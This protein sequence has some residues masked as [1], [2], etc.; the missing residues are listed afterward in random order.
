MEAMKA[1][2]A[3]KAMKIAVTTIT[4]KTMK[5]VKTMK[6]M[7]TIM[8]FN[9]SSKRTLWH[10]VLEGRWKRVNHRARQGNEHPSG[11]LR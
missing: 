9:A 11:T 3:R 6:A 10:I 4:K 2:K 7:K 5:A 8:N 1:V